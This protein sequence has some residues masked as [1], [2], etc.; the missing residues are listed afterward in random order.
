MDE[1][2]EVPSIDEIV[3]NL[4]WS[5][6]HIHGAI[7]GKLAGLWQLPA[8]CIGSK[9]VRRALFEAWTV[10]NDTP[11]Q[12]MRRSAK[13][14]PSKKAAESAQPQLGYGNDRS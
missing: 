1:Q 12:R 9:I 8:I 10:T 13:R 14:P 4:R 2:N 3:A 5:K 11:G 6:A 7:K